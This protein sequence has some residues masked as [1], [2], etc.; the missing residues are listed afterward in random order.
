MNPVDGTPWKPQQLD[1]LLNEPF[2]RLQEQVDH[3]IMARL[4]AMS[5]QLTELEAELD[6]IVQEFANC[7]Q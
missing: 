6:Q 2:E 4:N 1:E 7:P 5:L 3:R